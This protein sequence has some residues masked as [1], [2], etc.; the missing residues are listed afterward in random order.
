MK[1]RAYRSTS[2]KGV[3]VERLADLVEGQR[4]V[5]GIDVAKEKF[6]ATLMDQHQSVL[7]TLRWHHPLETP[8]FVELLAKLPAAQ[9]EVATE[10][11]GTYGLAVEDQLRRVQLPVFQVSPKRAHDAAEV[12]DGVP[13][14]HDAKSAAII[15]KLHLDGLSHPV[16]RRSVER[17]E[18]AAAIGVMDQHDEQLRRVLNRLEAH[19]AAHWPELT[20]HLEL[21]TVSTL[22][23]LSQ[24][25]CA[26]QVTARSAEAS[27]VLRR[28]SRWNLK[29]ET[30]EQVVRSARE[31]V[32]LNPVAGEITAVKEL[33]FEA[34]RSRK[35]LR[36][37][38][39]RVRELGQH[40]DQIRQMSVA[41]GQVTAAVLFSELGA[42]GEYGSTRAYVKACGLN[43][44]VHQSGKKQGR[45]AITKRG[46]GRA[47]KYLMFF[48]LRMIQRD[49][50]AAAWYQK[51]V[52]R[53]GGTKM[54]AVV[55]LMRKLLAAMWHV[56]RGAV[57]DSSKLFD[58]RRLELQA[59]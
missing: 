18:L 30:I 8:L 35:L 48:A 28:A 47:R 56:G 52:S 29:S 31:T 54:K 40:E 23:L 2:V 37:C 17:R 46:S 34:L 19:L 22:T 57:F 53:D 55:A 38:Q 59:S 41:A 58:A 21:G 50:L 45:L 15:A 33:A 39:Q 5:V 44:K 11:S 36:Q 10:P 20:Q 49:A 13:S 32:G 27:E 6:F 1:K 9:I 4:I 43:L 42:P 12:Y 16:A 26:A 3:C 7:S 24:Y 25:G 14:H 51:K